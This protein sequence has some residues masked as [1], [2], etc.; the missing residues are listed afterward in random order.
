MVM[1]TLRVTL[2]VH[3]EEQSGEDPA[4]SWPT[5]VR[6]EVVREVLISILQLLHLEE[7]L[8]DGDCRVE[9]GTRMV[10]DRD[11]GPEH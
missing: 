1:V 4:E 3:E 7:S 11:E 10:I 8:T 5:R 9:T 6:I 2:F